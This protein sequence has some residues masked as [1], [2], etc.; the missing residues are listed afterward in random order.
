MDAP[1]AGKT[2]GP[3][4]RPPEPPTRVIPSPAEAETIA[5]TP[6]P[7][8]PADSG[9]GTACMPQGVPVQ[10]AAHTRY[11]IICPLGQGG[12]GSV[13]LAEHRQM[14][15][16]VAL[17]VINPDLTNNA[18]TVRRFRQEVTAAAQ[19]GAHPNVVAVYDADQVGDLHFLVMEYVEGQ[20]LADYLRLKGPLPFAEACDYVRQAALGLQHASEQGMVHRDVKPHNLMRTPQGLI[21]VLDFGLARCGRETEKAKTQLTQQGV[22]MGTADYMAPEQASDSR[23]ADRRADVY[24]LGCTLYHLLTGRVPFPEGGTVEKIIKHA[25]EAPTPVGALRHDLPLGVVRAVEK[26]MAKPVDQR[27]Q[28]PGEVAEA[29]APWSVHTAGDSRVPTVI[30]LPTVSPLMSRPARRPMSVPILKPIAERRI[31]SCA[32]WLM[33][34][35]YSHGIVGF[36][37]LLGVGGIVPYVGIVVVCVATLILLGAMKMRARQSFAW[38]QCAAYL[39][40]IP[41]SPCFPVTFFFALRAV[42]C[43]NDPQTRRFFP[44]ARSR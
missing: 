43:L 11:R 21:K 9:P 28:S 29:L 34:T 27:F 19:L 36:G 33:V 35:G 42:S 44:E 16:K 8:T 2:A 12:M 5:P 20:S 18:D 41:M 7:A 10:L 31:R 6:P 32:F 38:A 17:K 1:D 25:V 24:S 23:V 15:R 30:A 13:Y 4:P 22:L 26:M 37:M 40:L 14:E 39:A 3:G